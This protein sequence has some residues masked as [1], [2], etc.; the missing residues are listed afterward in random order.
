[1]PPRGSRSHPLIL[2]AGSRL[3]DDCLQY[4]RN[5]RSELPPPQDPGHIAQQYRSLHRGGL[6]PRATGDQAAPIDG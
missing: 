6:R 5:Q 4:L 1:V 2:P 3:P